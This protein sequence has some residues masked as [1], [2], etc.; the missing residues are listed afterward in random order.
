MTKI[1]L[2]NETHTIDVNGHVFDVLISDVDILSIREEWKGITQRFDVSKPEG[3]IQLDAYVTSLFD[4]T[5]GKGALEVIA[6]GKPVSVGCK[7][8]WFVQLFN[9]IDEMVAESLKR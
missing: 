6:E 9:T 8:Q 5:I 7:V 2:A 3:I 1:Q 4:R